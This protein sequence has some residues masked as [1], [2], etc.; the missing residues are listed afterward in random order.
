MSF[1]TFFIADAKFWLLAVVAL[2]AA[3]LQPVAAE[4][5]HRHRRPAVSPI[6]HHLP[7][8]TRPRQY[9]LVVARFDE[10]LGW[11]KQVPTFWMVTVLNKGKP[12]V[13]ALRENVEV[14]HCPQTNE[15]GREG[16]LIAAYIYQRWN[17]LAEYT[18]FC[19]GFPMEHNPQYIELLDQP[20]LLSA[21]QPMSYIYK[22]GVTSAEAI[23]LN[24]KQPLYRSEVISLRTLDSVYFRDDFIWVVAQQIAKNFSVPLGTNLMSYYLGSVGLP[25]WISEDQETGHFAYGGMIGVHKAKILQHHM[26]VY[27]RISTSVNDFRWTGVLLERAWL[28]L[29]GGSD[30]RDP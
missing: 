3:L 15:N 23:N 4:E 20:A 10:E 24:K 22:P 25:G 9:E 21:V 13:A 14:I 18:A 28:M 17:S 8:P 11:L 2:S 12:D 5:P 30:Y 6:L 7:I 16:E 29:F 1:E 19:Q 26:E 27:A